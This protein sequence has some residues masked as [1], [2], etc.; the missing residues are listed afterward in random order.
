METKGRSVSS[1]AAQLKK[2]DCSLTSSFLQI[3]KLMTPD[4]VTDTDVKGSRQVMI[5][6]REQPVS[7]SLPLPPQAWTNSDIFSLLNS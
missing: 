4:F 1:I 7:L 5:T 2:G 6:H 3:E